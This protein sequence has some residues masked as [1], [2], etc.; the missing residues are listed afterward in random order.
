MATAQRNSV[1][2][3]T[4]QLFICCWAIFA[5]SSNA[6]ADRKAVKP[7]DRGSRLHGPLEYLNQTLDI[8]TASNRLLGRAAREILDG[9]GDTGF[10]ALL[11]IFSQPDV[12][13]PP[14]EGVSPGSSYQQ[15]FNLLAKMDAETQAAWV[16][17][18]EPVAR[19]ALQQANGDSAELAIVTRKFP[20]TPSGAKALSARVFLARSR[21]QHHLAEALLRELESMSL[22]DAN[23]L[24]KR[25]QE[26]S[27][28]S[29]FASI[30]GTGAG[31]RPRSLSAPWPE[32]KWDWTERL[33]DH[34]ETTAFSQLLAPEARS[35]FRLNS[36]QPTLCEDTIYMKTPFHVVAFDKTSG[37][38]KWS[39]TTDTMERID[40]T[41]IKKGRAVQSVANLPEMLRR[42]SMG[43]VAVSEHFVFFV[44]H[45]R[46]SESRNST[47]QFGNRGLPQD[48]YMPLSGPNRHGS[49]L[50][51]IKHTSGAAVAWVIGDA[52]DFDYELA[53]GELSSWA[54]QSFSSQTAAQNNVEPKK[55]QAGTTERSSRDNQFSGQHFC[56]VPVVHDQMLFVVTQDREAYWLNCLTEATGRLLWKKNLANVNDE[57]TRRGRFL[58]NTATDYG[59]SLC[60]V[61]GD[62]VVCALNNGIVLG[63]SITDGQFLWATNLRDN[64]GSGSQAQMFN[65]LSAATSRPQGIRSQPALQGDR[66]YWAAPFSS[67]V[68]CIS[69]TTGEVIWQIPRMTTGVGRL[70][71]SADRY[72]VGVTDTAVITIG[73]R[74]VRGL[75]ID[76]GSEIW[77]TPIRD[78]T[79]RA[80]CN[81]SSCLIPLIDGT[82]VQVDTSDGSRNILSEAL[83][84]DH[85]SIGAVV[86]D[87]DVICL[88][89][90][91]SISVAETSQVALHDAQRSE[92]DQATAAMLAGDVIESFA[93]LEQISERRSGSAV[94]QQAARLLAESLL[95]LDSH[96]KAKFL[97]SDDWIAERLA[98]LSISPEQ[99]VRQAVLFG[100]PLNVDAP[101]EFGDRLPDLQFGADWVAR[102][103]VAAW[104]HL[105]LDDARQVAE[106][107]GSRRSIQSRTEH[108]ILYPDHV[109]SVDKQISF[110]RTLLADQR[111]AAAELFLLSARRLAT[112]S[113]IVR[114]DT[115]VKRLRRLFIPDR[116]GDSRTEISGLAITE[117]QRLSAATSISLLRDRIRMHVDS[118]RWYPERLFVS[119]RALVSASF[120]YGVETSE[121]RLPDS[122]IDLIDLPDAFETPSI[123]PIAAGDS[124][125]VVSLLNPDGPRILWWRRFQGAEFDN[126]A[127]K[128][129]PFGASYLTASVGGEIVCLHPLTGQ[130]LWRRQTSDDIPR[131]GMLDRFPRLIGNSSVMARPGQRMKSYELFRTQDGKML[132][133]VGV[134]I[135]DGQTPLCS[136]H[137]ILYLKDRQLV[138]EELL[139]QKNLLAN[140]PPIT[141]MG[142][143][144]ALLLSEHRAITLTEEMDLLVLNMRSGKVESRCS[145][146]AVVDRDKVVGLKAFERNGSLFVVLKDWNSAR[147]S[148]SA[149]SRMGDTRLDSGLLCRIDAKSGQ[150]LWHK[151]IVPCVVPV[152][153]GPATNLMVTWSWKNKVSLLEQQL[154]GPRLEMDQDE[155]RR[156][157]VVTAIN[158]DT[159]ATV[160]ES[161]QLNPVEP[162]RC[163]HNHGQNVIRLESDTSVIR[164]KYN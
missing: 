52:P 102:A 50:V 105:S 31:Q 147:S 120:E 77:A 138:L 6:E 78:Q 146:A 57:G 129:G 48:N 72:V 95:N 59:A 93:S 24:R 115:E 86:A 71:G 111:H 101:L 160:A 121:L 12:I 91:L 90:P 51:A 108:A 164:L 54:T 114:I 22:Q 33:W 141:V 47:F 130:Q 143:G 116:S 30:A 14:V 45:F 92:I 99:Q 3:L 117:E 145:V 154:G 94:G 153:Y 62:V 15:A 75:G 103:D 131:Q 125:A 119:G 38:I 55:N 107:D 136:G 83:S 49:R 148:H 137:S 35:A 98:R 142:A 118:P 132:S 65:M 155:L 163:V 156:T 60:G 27:S 66:L 5:F 11:Q 150:L 67:D 124:L 76:D 46:I 26:S 9:Y 81:Q 44:D 16:E 97:L 134:D 133:T 109:G 63:T 84:K 64:Q 152:I 25:F 112:G 28:S 139:T 149:S 79:G 88:A 1:V 37:S 34:P 110:A 151:Q 13:A 53:V 161:T 87:D 8:S 41:Q 56:G 126:S 32:P 96:K 73:A 10:Q 82:L 113:D 42:D 100:T 158:L 17:S 4:R 40:T 70:E 127:I 18:V 23:S 80:F 140:K 7:T 29:R 135:P 58:I 36:W 104:N 39:L 157:M 144:Q 2:S 20:F 61:V 159:G 162:L 21:G 128:L 123:I 69:V 122:P 106:F 89:T 68:H 19:Q 43:T 74:H 85:N